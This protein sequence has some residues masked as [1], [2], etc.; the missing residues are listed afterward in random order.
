MLPFGADGFFCYHSAAAGE[1][2]LNPHRMLSQQLVELEQR[3]REIATEKVA[4]R[5]LS[6]APLRLAT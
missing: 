4:T 2:Y 5:R 3:F 6:Y 1:K